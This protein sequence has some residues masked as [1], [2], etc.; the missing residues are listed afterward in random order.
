MLSAMALQDIFG[1]TIVQG[2]VKKI[3]HYW[4][5][6]GKMEVD[7]TGDQFGKGFAP[8]RVKCGKL[9]TRP[10]PYA[11]FRRPY[12]SLEQPANFVACTMHDRFIKRLAEQLRKD[13]HPV[14]AGVLSRGGCV[15][16]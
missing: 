1:G 6:F 13:G 9:H 10:T 5:R 8:I 12:E 3:P 2:E 15:Q 7:L 16:E 4:N 11:F 14:W